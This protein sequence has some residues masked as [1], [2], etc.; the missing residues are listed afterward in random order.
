MSKKIIR[1]TEGQLK[2]IIE[3]QILTE[4]MR[5]N[6]RILRMEG[7]YEIDELIQ[8]LEN[9]LSEIKLWKDQSGA[10]NVSAPTSYS[11]WIPLWRK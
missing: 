9:V 8:E 3:N 6:P 4:G 5:V 1:I 11:E 10:T 7:E 2:Q